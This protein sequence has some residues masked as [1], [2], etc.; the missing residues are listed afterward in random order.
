MQKG[1]IDST[2]LKSL[3]IWLLHPLCLANQ[4]WFWN[5]MERK[6]KSKL[7]KLQCLNSEA[8]FWAECNYKFICVQIPA[9][10][11]QN[12]MTNTNS[13]SYWVAVLELARQN[14]CCSWRRAVLSD[15]PVAYCDTLHWHIVPYSGILHWHIGH[16]VGYCEH[17]TLC[18]FWGC[19]SS[20]IGRWF[21]K[22]KT[23]TITFKTKTVHQLL[24]PSLSWKD[25]HHYQDKIFM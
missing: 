21:I 8:C 10:M 15:I 3:I 5:E 19:F 9:T 16:N 24:T 23:A 6:E 14:M 20:T 13:V 25:H 18:Y 17:L 7:Y 12:T 2:S 1:Q 4:L 22:E 11:W